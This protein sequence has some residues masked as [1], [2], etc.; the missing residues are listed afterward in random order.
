MQTND[1]IDPISSLPLSA[2]SSSQRIWT[3]T[4]QWA[5]I[6]TA[7]RASLLTPK[8]PERPRTSFLTHTYINKAANHPH[9]GTE[10]CSAA[11]AHSGFRITHWS[12]SGGQEG[13]LAAW[14]HAD[15]HFESR[16]L[17]EKS[18]GL[19]PFH[20]PHTG[21]SVW[22]W[23][24]NISRSSVTPPCTFVACADG[25]ANQKASNPS[26]YNQILTLTQG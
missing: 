5:T 1:K 12:M 25:A 2:D 24:N 21:V 15:V 22:V 26:Y 20:F 19:S 7:G 10:F 23:S 13:G 18:C 11:V 4:S 14:H 16:W 6:G 17:A 8:K 9:G 3:F